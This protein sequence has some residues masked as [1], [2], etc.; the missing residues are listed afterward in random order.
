MAAETQEG[1]I[2]HTEEILDE[3]HE[4]AFYE[5]PE[6]WV[7]VSF[8]LFL[9]V[10]LFYKIPAMIAK[11]L[12]ARADKIT[13]DLEE[14]RKLREEAQ[15]LLAQYERQQRDAESQAAEIVTHASAES[16]RIAED[17]EKALEASISRREQL[18][19][20][21]I[22]QAEA[23]AVKEVQTVAVDVATEVSRKLIAEGLSSDKAEDL[24]ESAIGDLPKHLH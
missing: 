4:E 2:E 7:F 11:A 16:K 15:N 14:A 6:F 5:A 9:G 17:A 8:V 22:A 13:T 23:A 1:L 18:A 20:D 12:D 10:L 19:Q 24:I 21:K 3:V